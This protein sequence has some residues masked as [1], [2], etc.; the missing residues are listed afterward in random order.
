MSLSYLPLKTRTLSMQVAHPPEGLRTG[1]LPR[2]FT[3]NQRVWI[4]KETQV[5]RFRLAYHAAGRAGRIF[6]RGVV[7]KSW[8]MGLR[9]EHGAEEVRYDKQS[10]AIAGKLKTFSAAAANTH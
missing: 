2:L 9:K 1:P 10:D 6:C 5:G 8:L 7:V 3:S 4:S